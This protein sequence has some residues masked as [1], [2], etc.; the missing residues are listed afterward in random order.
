M[1]SGIV[2][3]RTL[4]AEDRKY[5]HIRLPRTSLHMHTQSSISKRSWCN[6]P[7]SSR[8]SS[9]GRSRSKSRSRSRSRS[10]GRSKSRSRSRSSRRMSGCT[11]G[12]VSVLYVYSACVS[13][14]LYTL[15][16]VYTLVLCVSRSLGTMVCTHLGSHVSAWCY[17]AIVSSPGANIVAPRYA[18]FNYAFVVTRALSIV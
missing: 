7:S 3:L 1:N 9:R 5:E 10:R 4:L 11:C 6:K 12:H 14:S 8:G 15:L 18:A 13:Q 17:D 16:Y 2:V